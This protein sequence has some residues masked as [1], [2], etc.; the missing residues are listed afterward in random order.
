MPVIQ[1]Y[2]Y[3]ALRNFSYLIYCSKSNITAIIDP[4]DGKKT[5]ELIQKNNLIPKY[6]INT[7]D[8]W[9]HIQ[10]NSFLVKNYDLDVVYQKGYED[11]FKGITKTVSS[12]E[13]LELGQDYLLDFQ[14]SPGHR[15]SHLAIFLKKARLNEVKAIF[16]GDTLF[17]AGVGNCKNGGNVEHLYETILS[18]YDDLDDNVILYPGH[19]Y[20]INNLEFSLSVDKKEDIENFLKEKKHPTDDYNSE[21]LAM[22]VEKKINLFL[23]NRREHLKKHP[24]FAKYNDKQ[25]FIKLRD[26]RDKW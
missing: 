12:G 9:D 13:S 3:N 11:A 14:R 2:N 10:G 16:S 7:H 4:F 22:A 25:V 20:L 19:D 21:P 24:E 5:K 17:N 1:Q 8:H 18:I 6:I 26:L 23:R 15:E